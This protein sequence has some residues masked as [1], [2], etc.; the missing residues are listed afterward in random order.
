MALPVLAR[1]Y[2]TRHWPSTTLP[3][4]EAHPLDGTS[5]KL[6]DGEPLVLHFWATWCATCRAE[7]PSIQRL[8]RHARVVSVPAFS[9]SPR[10]VQRYVRARGVGFPVS[11]DPEGKLA[12]RLGVYAYP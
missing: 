6:P 8:A 1:V 12:E 7:E 5:F 4:L 9:G 11:T 2:Q 3:E 10:D